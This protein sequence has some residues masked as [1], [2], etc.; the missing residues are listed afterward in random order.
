MWGNE[1]GKVSS[2][3]GGN[4]GQLLPGNGDLVAI[5]NGTGGYIG[6]VRGNDKLR[7]VPHCQGW[8]HFF[9]ELVDNSRFA[10]RQKESNHYLGGVSNNNE[11]L[12]LA[13]Q[14]QECEIFTYSLLPNGMVNILNSKM[15]KISRRGDWLYLSDQNTLAESWNFE[16]I[17]KNSNPTSSTGATNMAVNSSV[18]STGSTNANGLIPPPGTV[19]CIESRTGGF[20]GRVKGKG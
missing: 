16:M 9:F 12:F 10:L 11:Q 14:R 18:N 5:K 8:E 17:Q 4:S 13:N 1:T 2:A 19:V 6:G 7:I 3:V 20:I 15:N